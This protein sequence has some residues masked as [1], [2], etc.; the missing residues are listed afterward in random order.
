MLSEAEVR[1]IAAE[2]NHAS[3]SL[4][5]RKI[6]SH[7]TENQ[8]I[9]RVALP[10]NGL[11][12]TRSLSEAEVRNIEDEKVN[13]QKKQIKMKKSIITLLTFAL[14][15]TTFAQFDN[16]FEYINPGIV[17]FALNEHYFI[18]VR[19]ISE[20]EFYVRKEEAEH[21]QHQ[22][23]HK[24]ITDREE[25]QKLLK[26]RIRETGED[27]DPNSRN[28]EITHKDGIT[29]LH[30]T[31]WR[32]F[33]AYYPELGILMMRCDATSV[34]DLNHS[35]EIDFRKMSDPALHNLS[36]DKQWR[37]NGFSLDSPASEGRSHFLEKWNSKTNQFEFVGNFSLLA[38]D[39]DTVTTDSESKVIS[40][41]W[42]IMD[43][44]WVGNSKAIFGVGGY[45]RSYFEME[46][47]AH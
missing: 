15:F 19:Q 42:S 6:I 36:P 37:L 28:L 16:D 25:A 18:R 33:Y 7:K 12:T 22:N 8:S 1:E 38:S 47:I 14:A 44:F 40:A 29:R 26:D 17:E 41:F 3:T 23:N 20:N 32:F 34:I 31:D 13:E 35:A 45:W 24:V 9:H 2:N 30:Y 43:W 11:S 4:S 5:D 46:I 10:S 27:D 39:R 21:L